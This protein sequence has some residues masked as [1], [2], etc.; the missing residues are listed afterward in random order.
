MLALPGKFGESTEWT[1][2][3]R[4]DILGV[5]ISAINMGQTLETIDE[6]IATGA[7]QYVC[8]TNTHN[9]M[10]SYDD[11]HL[12]T[13]HNSAGLT[14]PDGMPMVWISRWRGQK[15]VDRVYGP[16]LLLELSEHSVERGYKHFF[17]GGAEGVPERLAAEMQKRY[18]GLDVVGTISPPYRD[19][20]APEDQEM[21]DQINASGADIVWVG[22]GCPKQELWMY[23]HVGRLKAPVLIGIGAAFDFHTGMKKQA[24]KWMRHAGLEMVFRVITEPRR[25]GPRLL[26]NH[27]RF[28]ALMLLDTLGIRRSSD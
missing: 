16:D 5:Q 21:V 1:N 3:N 28:V 2:L 22:L 12:R 20:T 9:I 23:E 8:I 26:K 10:M 19:L 18:P 4:T 25:L 14:T 6:W 7:S 13:V 27:P 11:P 24:P 17:Y 15:H